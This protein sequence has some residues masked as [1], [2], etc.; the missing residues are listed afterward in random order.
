MAGNLVA[1][2]LSGDF[3]SDSDVVKRKWLLETSSEYLNASLISEILFF[4]N[5]KK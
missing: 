4:Q 1:V 5:K 2:Y 3:D